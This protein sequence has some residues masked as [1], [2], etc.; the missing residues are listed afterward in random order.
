M[1]IKNYNCGL[2]TVLPEQMQDIVHSALLKM[3][4]EKAFQ[5]FHDT[6]PLTEMFEPV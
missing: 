6:E 4:N 3:L 2:W 5:I 1:C